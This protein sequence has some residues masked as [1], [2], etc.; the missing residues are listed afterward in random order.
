MNAIFSD[1]RGLNLLRV[2]GLEKGSDDVYFDTKCGRT[3]RL[4]HCQSCCESVELADF[5]VHGELSGEIASADEVSLD[6]T[7]VDGEPEYMDS[8]TW[9]FY[10]LHTPRGS[11]NMRWLGESNG[12]YSESV[13][14]EEV[15][16]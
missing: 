5:E 12:Y 16:P 9:T 10:N 2:R 4:Y 6:D 7:R 8:C 1:L 14:F 11:L 3:F 15:T 13:D